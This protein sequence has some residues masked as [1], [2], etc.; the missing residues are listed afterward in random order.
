MVFL[1]TSKAELEDYKKYWVSI[2]K[3]SF[4]QPT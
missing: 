2:W 1:D 3:S 4:I